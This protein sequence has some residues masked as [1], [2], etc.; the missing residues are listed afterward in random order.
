SQSPLTYFE[1][2]ERVQTQYD[3]WQYS[4][5][6]PL[7]QG[8]QR[9]REVCGATRWPSRSRI[10]LLKTEEGWRI[11]AGALC[12]MTKGSILAFYPPAVS[13]ARRK[14]LGHVRVA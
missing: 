13:K 1:L 12:G 5:S 4:G 8:A 6:T 2:I 9:D 7:L 3:T 10:A 11:N 14:A